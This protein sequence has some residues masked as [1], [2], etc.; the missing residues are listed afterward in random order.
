[1]SDKL[2]EFEKQLYQVGNAIVDEK[3]KCFFLLRLF[4]DLVLELSDTSSLHFN[5]MFARVSFIGSRYQ[6]TRSWSYALQI[7]RRELKQRQSSHSE[8]IKILI[9]VNT[10][11]LSIYKVEV[12]PHADLKEII[13][14]GLPKLPPTQ[15]AGRYKKKFA[16]VVV[17]AWQNENKTMTILDE[18]LPD[19]E[20]ILK[21]AVEGINDLYADT[22]EIA[23]R[24][25]G[26]P[27]IL[28]LVDIETND[29]QHY[30]PSFIVILPDLLLDVTSIAQATHSNGDPQAL[31]LI[32]LFLPSDSTEA[33]LTG[34]VA[35][36]FLD[37]LVRDTTLSYHEVFTQSFKLFPI[38]FVQL[39][40][41][42][43]KKM[44]S[45]MEQ[46]FN[47]IRS[48]IT[49][50]FPAVG[51]DREQCIIEP[52][53]FSPQ[54]GI[55]GRLDLFYQHKTEQGASIV[56]L[57]SSKPFKPN[58]Y[59]LSS[60]NYHQTLLYELLIRSVLGPMHYRAN[61]ILY[62]PMTDNPLR[63]A[64]SVESIQKETIQNR[65]ELVVLQFRMLR[66]DQEGG[67]DIFQ[68]ITTDRY[69]DLKGYVKTNI[70]CWEKVYSSLSPGE[71]QYFKYLTAFITREHILA[72]IGNEGVEGAAGL[73]GLWL[74]SPTT[75]D[76]QYRI[77]RELVL[78]VIDLSDHQTRI[79]FRKSASTNK[80]ANFRAGDIA[81]MYPASEDPTKHQIYRAN[82]LH[83]GP[84]EIIIKLRNN[85]VNTDQ[86]EAVQQWN[87][88]HD[89]LDSSFKSLYQS[90][91]SFMCSDI[92]KRQLIFGLNKPFITS[93]AQYPYPEGL[94]AHQLHIYHE[95]LS[96]GPLYL[97]WGPP[98][99]GKTSRM[100][101]SW[102]WYYFFHSEKRIALLAY[103]NKAVDEMCEALLEIGE[104][105]SLHYLRI[106][107]RA[108]SG[109]KY[110][111]RLL[112]TVMSPMTK[113][114]EIRQ[115]LE[116]TR[117][118]VGTIASLQ[119]KNEIF[120][121]IHF[122]I[123]II[124][125]ASQIL[126]PSMIGLLTR[127]E[128]TILIGDHMQL[129]A[130]SAQPIKFRHIDPAVQWAKR[131]GMTDTGM[132]YF[133]RI[134]RLYTKQ[135]WH[136]V[137]GILNEQGRMHKE[138]QQYANQH[139]YQ[140][141]LQLLHP[142][143]QSIPLEDITGDHE[144]V[145]FNKRL[146]FIPTTTAIN[147]VYQKTNANEA[148]ITIKT[149]AVWQQL[150]TERDLQWSIG[151]ITP[152]R[153]QIAAILHKAH[154][155]GINMNNVSVDTVERYQGGARDIIIMSAAVNSRQYLSRIVS[156][157]EEGI[158]RKLNV[159]VTRARQQF[160]LIGNRD[161]LQTEKAYQYL[162]N[163]A[164]LYEGFQRDNISGREVVIESK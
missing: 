135:Q 32:D 140:G 154:L 35:N 128:K 65:N 118:F 16:R 82:V 57:K 7:A 48:V 157:N 21:Y 123:A 51:I 86:I 25:L 52:S 29:E 126:E 147:E 74:D 97:L 163:M 115:L 61:Y 31:N 70:Q 39:S 53:Y 33:I 17:V 60:T 56:E 107:S 162:F 89:L 37:E 92:L 47:N 95:A 4:N 84:E 111:D 98:G 117:I 136:H 23:V 36:Y 133:E 137:I 131:I 8:L 59:G 83:A 27:L 104:E 87:L 142:E 149:I 18:E 85:Q 72:R 122:D 90:V 159:A 96:A 151:V 45:V 91:W 93:S 108:G 138:I 100:L 143:I 116:S 141:L 79:R 164:E 43:L 110:H 2:H 105:V 161:I 71:K 152:F 78:D 28:G 103:T 119:G 42:K 88:E 102:V 144:N 69:A 101:K 19:T 68:E 24:E 6:F 112:D 139:V 13:I 156:L 14:P 106:G 125:E 160:I 58:S 94:T 55:K 67:R 73:A 62:S 41:D 99:T 150:I 77:L 49:D 120:K 127:F 129:P 158:D 15:S 34:Q 30:I 3:E 66:L 64:V 10:Y 54:F 9:P 148:A 26:L 145:I 114:N 38:Q 155:E 5:T 124:D 113:R 12:S 20:I 50:R 146:V 134:Y 130:V 76:D 22:L 109:L 44:F 81:I 75:K 46:H 63:Y 132:S 121:L 40:N 80:L 11:L 153:A 1:M